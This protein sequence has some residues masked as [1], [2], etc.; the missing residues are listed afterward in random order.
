MKEGM[1]T[2]GGQDVVVKGS[3]ARLKNGVLAGSIL[4]LDKAVKNI[5][6]NLNVPLFEVIKMAS[7]NPAVHCNV[8]NRKGIIKEGYD[9]DLILFDDDIN[10]KKVFVLG[11]EV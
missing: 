4:T 7:Y 2:L 5:Y 6:K 8:Q 11:R 10:I 3:S 1:Y 9:A